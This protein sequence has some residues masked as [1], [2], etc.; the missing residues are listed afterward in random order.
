M[1]FLKVL[2]V[3]SLGL[4]VVVA[5]GWVTVRSSNL[6]PQAGTLLL[7]PER[8]ALQGGGY[9]R[10]DRGM[11]F[12][13]ANRSRPGGGVIGVEIYRFKSDKAAPGTPPVFRLHG[14]PGWGGLSGSLGQPGFY[15][16][17][18]VPQLETADLVV[19]GQRGI[20]S[21]KPDTVCDAPAKL[22]L[23]RKVSE[24]EE[25]EVLRQASRQCKDFW[26]ST[27]LD[28]S[29]LN[30]VEAAADVNDVRQALGY[31][32]IT[33][34]GRSFGSHWAM[35]VMRFHPDAVE[36]AVLTGM[37]GPD[38]TYDMPSWVL[39]ALE[40]IAKA[41]ESSDRLKE[42][43]PEGGLIEAFKSVVARLDE[44]PV[45]VSVPGGAEIYLDGDDIRDMAY[46]YS[47]RTSSRRGIQTWASDVLTLYAGDY[48]P[49]ARTVARQLARGGFPTASFFMLD[50]GSGIS[51]QRLQHLQS[52]PA[53]VVVG[54][55]GWF[56]QTACAEWGSDLGEAF[57]K[58]FETG[59]PTLI[60]QGDWDTS[61]PYEN[62]LELKPYFKNSTFV[63][64]RGGSHGALPEAMREDESF[65][66]AV[67]KFIG[68]GDVSG[69]PE[70]V[71]L[72]E[73]VWTKPSLS[74]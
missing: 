12:V 60:V 57:R 62:A 47:G 6:Q 59:I 22:P 13:P 17:E 48:D 7:Y 37:E 16:R 42:Q 49:A 24:E 39:K 35:A 8:I 32:K 26:E 41:A 54:D 28:L 58:N 11:M 25:A 21:S 51:R 5:A 15:Q 3:V 64:V 66:A 10:C 63:T 23:D 20:G 30:V 19:V 45:K 33:L 29:G 73:I 1:R 61:T 56:Y 67:M 55:L 14:G 2:A 31:G 69:I 72:P 4:A 44:E 68:E 38:H 46:G 27:G 36:R 40:R 65:S 71:Q 50:C 43:I 70:E 18:I 53:K 52:D 74:K 9:A 34:W